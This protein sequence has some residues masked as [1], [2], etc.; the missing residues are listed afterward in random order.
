MDLHTIREFARPGCR[1]ALPSWQ[2]GDAYLA[3]GTWLYSEPQLSLTRLIDLAALGWEPLR[4]SEDGLDIAATCT[5]AALDA[6]AVPPE[7]FTA[8][9]IGQCCRAFLASFKIWNAATV[10]GNVCLSLPA[11]PMIS[12]MS[13]LHGICT[14]WTPGGGER[15]MPVSDFVTG[16][17]RTSCRQ[18]SF[19]VGLSFPP[20]VFRAARRFA[21]LLLRPRDAPLPC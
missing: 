20:K 3:G 9:L 4:I 7:W 8:P 21:R 5:I 17:R 1:P 13:A 11:G 15:L 19:C 12:L 2:T 16:P 6:L 14:L 18:V 10:G